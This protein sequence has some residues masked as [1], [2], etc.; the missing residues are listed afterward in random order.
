MPNDMLVL[1]QRIRAREGKGYYI[2]LQGLL[3][4]TTQYLNET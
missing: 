1:C 2:L 4:N 3:L